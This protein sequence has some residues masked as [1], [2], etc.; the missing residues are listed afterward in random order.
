MEDLPVF[1]DDAE[2][3]L[4][5]LSRKGLEFIRLRDKPNCP[6]M[7]ESVSKVDSETINV[8]VSLNSKGSIVQKEPMDVQVKVSN[9]QEGR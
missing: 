7:I 1:T 4:K 5:V 8:E 3:M 6:F 9:I 2:D